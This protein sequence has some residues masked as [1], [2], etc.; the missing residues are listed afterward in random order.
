MLNFENYQKDVLVQVGMKHAHI[1]RQAD[2]NNAVSPKDV[3]VYTL[4]R[5]LY[6]APTRFQNN[7]GALYLS[8]S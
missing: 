8:L 7:V 6:L 3:I 2:V 4:A 1:N 5:V